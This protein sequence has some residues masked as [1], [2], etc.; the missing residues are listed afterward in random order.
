MKKGPENNPSWTGHL[1]YS[2]V[3]SAQGNEK[4]YVEGGLGRSMEISGLASPS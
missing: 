3:L 1:N 2:Q 4:K